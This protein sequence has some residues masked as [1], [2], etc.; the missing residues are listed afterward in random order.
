M[1]TQDPAM[2]DSPILRACESLSKNSELPGTPGPG[3]PRTGLGSRG[4]GLDFGTWQTTNFD[5]DE[6]TRSEGSEMNIRNETEFCGQ[7]AA[8]LICSGSSS[9]SPTLSL[10]PPYRRSR[11]WKAAIASS[12]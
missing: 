8:I 3:S 1:A 2:S 4:G 9:T 7:L 10:N 12:R 11:R 6:F 5:S